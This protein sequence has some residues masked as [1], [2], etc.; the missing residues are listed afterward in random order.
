MSYSFSVS[1]ATKADAKQKIAE[2]FDS[3]VTNQPPH[4]VDRDAAVTAG[5]A[6]VDMLED[7]ADGQEIHVSMHGSM[8]W[9][10][11]APETFTSAGVG[12]SA[13]V[14]AKPTA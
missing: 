6:F 7:P 9:R 1:A 10:H 11:D 2:A 3:V 14:R 4:A 5:G 12:I 13:T 8:G